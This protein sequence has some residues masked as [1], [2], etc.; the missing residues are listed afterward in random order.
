MF[1]NKELILTR[2]QEMKASG[3]TEDFL[4]AEFGR[5]KVFINKE[6]EY[7]ITIPIKEGDDTIYVGSETLTKK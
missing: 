7:I 1:Q 3:K 6:P 5:V 4:G 2:Y